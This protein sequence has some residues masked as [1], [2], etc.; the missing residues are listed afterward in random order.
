MKNAST[1]FFVVVLFSSLGLW[2]CTH[3]KNGAYHAKIRELENRYLKLEEDYRAVVQAGEQL[4]KRIG[5]LEA[6]RNQLAQRVDELKTIAKQRDEL[7]TQLAVRT[8][9]R[10]ALHGQLTHLRRD[11]ADLLGRIDTALAQPAEGSVAATPASR[12]SE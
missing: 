4:R 11:L 10:D 7:K 5:E 9:E 1:V 3:Q 8:G 2:G 12:K 6:Q